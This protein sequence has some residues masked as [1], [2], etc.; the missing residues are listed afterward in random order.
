M[1]HFIG[2][3]H[4]NT[5]SG[6][7]TLNYK[8]S[9]RSDFVLY[10]L[11]AVIAYN[12]M[13]HHLP[14]VL[15]YLKGIDKENDWVTLVVG[16]VDC[17]L[18]IPLHADNDNLDFTSAIDKVADRFLKC[19]DVLLKKGYKVFVVGT[20]PTTKEQHDMS[21]SSRPIYG[22]P[23]LRN[24]ICVIWNHRLHAYALRNKIPFI[25]IYNSLVNDDNTTDMSYFIDYCHLNGETVMPLII[26]ELKAE[27]IL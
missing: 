1:I 25:S 21:N 7:K 8:E 19:Y 22:S 20:H 16:E 6:S 9:T 17:R 5:Y 3:S 24:R 11:G 10:H 15:K 26:K 13:E 4:V 2:N 23:E 12:F 14:R 18:H 27:N